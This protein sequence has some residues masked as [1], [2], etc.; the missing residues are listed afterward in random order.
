LLL[1]VIDL[2][3][4][5]P[6][7]K[8]NRGVL[9]PDP[10]AAQREAQGECAVVEVGGQPQPGVEGL[11]PEALVAWE[12]K[13]IRVGGGGEETLSARAKSRSLAKGQAIPWWR[14]ARAASGS[15]RQ[16]GPCPDLWRTWSE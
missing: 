9:E 15:A 10:R 12:E 14:F 8:R 11:G 1:G 13:R 4:Q 7:G 3:A 5:G 6:D 2:D 16:R